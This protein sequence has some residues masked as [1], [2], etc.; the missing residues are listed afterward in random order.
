MAGRRHLVAV[1]RA[2]RVGGLDPDGVDAPTIELAR[3]LARKIDAVGVENASTRLTDA[4]LSASGRLVRAAARVAA[5]RARAERLRPA[6]PAPAEVGEDGMPPKLHAVERDPLT[7]FLQ[8]KK[9]G[10]QRA[11]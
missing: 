10:V 4:Y 11:S 1:N 2:I 3:D 5:E 6:E 9:I 7:A 8:D